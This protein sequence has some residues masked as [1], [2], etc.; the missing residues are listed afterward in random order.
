MEAWTAHNNT[1]QRG[2]GGHIVGEGEPYS[3]AEL[4][5]LA[6]LYVTS[7]SATWS[8]LS[9]TVCDYPPSHL[10]T[11]WVVFARSSFVDLSFCH[12]LVSLSQC[13][14]S[15]RCWRTHSSIRLFT[16][17]QEH[18]NNELINIYD[19]PYLLPSLPP[20][21]NFWTTQNYKMRLALVVRV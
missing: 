11:Y 12:S 8:L 15:T 19:V 10:P 21:G 7:V 20:H 2:H 17:T 4:R 16:V 5:Q 9:L 6:Q 3:R 1:I 14:L 18:L 13:G